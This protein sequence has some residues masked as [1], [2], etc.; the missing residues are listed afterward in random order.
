MTA[1]LIRLLALTAL[2]ALGGCSTLSSQRASVMEDG[3]LPCP[4]QPRCV[5]S[6]E[7]SSRHIAGFTLTN[8]VQDSWNQVGVILQSMPRTKIT[9]QDERHIHAE[10]S[11]PTGMYT[12]DVDLRVQPDSRLV[13]IRSSARIGYYDFKVNRKRVELLRSKLLEAGVIQEP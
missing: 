8:D 6:T 4:S 5:S 3:S 11:S 9:E 13:D 12:D 1:T 10:V 2:A 7:A